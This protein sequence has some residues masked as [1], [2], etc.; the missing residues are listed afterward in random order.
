M[1][2]GDIIRVKTVFDVDLVKINDYTFFHSIRIH[3]DAL[4]GKSDNPIRK[5]LT[6]DEL[7]RS[8][9]FDRFEA[10][11]LNANLPSVAHNAILNAEVKEYQATIQI[12]GRERDMYYS[13]KVKTDGILYIDEVE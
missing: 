13:F 7:I 9:E 1:A 2:Y 11:T 6:E 3:K 12:H 10:I 4:T 8:L 5:N